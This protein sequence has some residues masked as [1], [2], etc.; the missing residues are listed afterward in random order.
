LLLCA[1]R[2]CCCGGGE[3]AVDALIQ[4][5]LAYSLSAIAVSNKE[6]PDELKE[7]GKA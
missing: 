6:C 2:C 5:Q 3:G 4:G 1:S 7:V